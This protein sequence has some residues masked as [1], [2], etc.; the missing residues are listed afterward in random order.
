VEPPQSVSIVIVNW[1]AGEHL[2]ACLRSVAEHPPPCPCDVVV[3]DNASTDG[4]AERAREELA[5]ARVIHNDENRGL[6]AGNNQGI[7]ESAGD[8]VLICNPDVVFREGSIAALLDLFARRPRAAFAIPR[9][10][11]PDGSL[12]TGTGDL[13]T[14]MDALRGRRAAYRRADDGTKRAFWWDGWAHDAERRIGHGAEAAY[15]VRRR[16]LDEI[17]LQDER[18]ILDW[19]GIDWAARAAEAGWEVWFTPRSEI[20]HAGGASIGQI[21]ARWVVWTHRSMARYLRRHLGVTGWLA[22]PL[23]AA[24]AVTKLA[25]RLGPDYGHRRDV[26]VDPPPAAEGSTPP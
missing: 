10:L 26:P 2:R 20:V 5:S 16:A 11:H 17:G 3:I 22:Q 24:R 12:Q 21:S 25:A 6:A 8:A 1:N 15:L 23:V 9:L 4:S 13:P 18:F 14:V 19:E 7:R